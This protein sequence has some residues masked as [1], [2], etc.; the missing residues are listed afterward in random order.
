MSCMYNHLPIPNAPTDPSLDLAGNLFQENLTGQFHL[1][2]REIDVATK[3]LF[4]MRFPGI[5]PLKKY[6][7]GLDI[8]IW[9]SDHT[10]LRF[11]E[12]VAQHATE[13]ERLRLEQSLM[14]IENL[15]ASFQSNVD[16]D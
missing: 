16:L 8:V 1:R 3:N 12:V 5:K 13:E 9:K 2:L 14:D 11:G 10:L 7:D 15:H 4:I 6:S